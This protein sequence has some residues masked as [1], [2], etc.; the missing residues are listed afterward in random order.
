MCHCIRDNYMELAHR[1]KVE[2]IEKFIS[3]WFSLAVQVVP[4]KV[5]S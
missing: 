3:V 4:E 1:I 2:S 5:Y